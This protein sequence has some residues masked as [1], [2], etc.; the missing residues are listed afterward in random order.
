MTI[1]T[2]KQHL[3]SVVIPAY[4]A[5][6]YIKHAIDSIL[7]QSH[8]DLEVIIVN[9]GSTDNTQAIVMSFTDPRVRLVNKT[10]GGMSSA[11]NAGVDQAKGEYLAFLDADDYWMPDK[12][13][14]QISLLNKKPNIGFCSTM[15]TFFG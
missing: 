10:N 1:S 5:E 13:E 9:D 7:C 12:L 6:L 3:V 11:R 2:G 15:I 14:K 8:S 4:N